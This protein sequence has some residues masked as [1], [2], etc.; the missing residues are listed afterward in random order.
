MFSNKFEK[1]MSLQ[2]DYIER[3]NKNAVKLDKQLN[4]SAN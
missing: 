2:N 4:F 3:I 1:L